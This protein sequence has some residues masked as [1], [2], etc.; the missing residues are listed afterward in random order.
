MLRRV[1]DSCGLVRSTK[2]WRS[3]HVSVPLLSNI[4]TVGVRGLRQSLICLCL[5]YEKC[6][7]YSPLKEKSGRK[8]GVQVTFEQEV[9]SEKS[10]DM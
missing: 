8:E 6:A 1:S 3:C 7:F 10:Y 4:L 9:L 2:Q 5:V